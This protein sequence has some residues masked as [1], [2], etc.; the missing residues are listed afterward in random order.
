MGKNKTEEGRNRQA[1]TSRPDK[2]YSCVICPSVSRARSTVFKNCFNE[3]TESR[4]NRSRI[5]VRGR[6]PALMMTMLRI[7]TESS[8]VPCNLFPLKKY[9][10]IILYTTLPLAKNRHP[11]S[12]HNRYIQGYS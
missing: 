3:L 4:F 12:F 7:F 6:T 1:A 8:P 10:T 9:H 2:E 11:L 5:L